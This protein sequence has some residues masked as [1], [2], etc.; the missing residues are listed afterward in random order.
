MSGLCLLRTWKT[1]VF[2]VHLAMAA[3]S[4]DKTELA[5][6][7]SVARAIPLATIQAIG[8]APKAG[9]PRWIVLAGWLSKAE[10]Q[11]KIDSLLGTQE[12][13]ALESDRRFERVSSILASTDKVRAA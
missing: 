5:R 1:K 11:H 10:N 4:V 3:L 2:P 8:P 9:R 12:F 13:K 6:L 7:L